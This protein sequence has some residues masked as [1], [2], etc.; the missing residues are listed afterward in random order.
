MRRLKVEDRYAR[1]SRVVNMHAGL[2]CLA[3]IVD[4]VYVEPV[5]VW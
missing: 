1:S 5:N 3:D 4:R 2:T